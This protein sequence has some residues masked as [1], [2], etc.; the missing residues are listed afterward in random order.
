MKI[1]HVVQYIFEDLPGGIQKFV[2]DLSKLQ[3]EH[4]HE[5]VVYT[6]RPMWFRGRCSTKEN[7][8]R[9]RA[10]EVL[11]TP[12]TPFMP[13]RFLVED[14][15]VV[16]IHAQFPLVGEI[17]AFLSKIRK[18]P[19][20]VS[21]HNEAELTKTSFIVKLF[22]FFHERFLVRKL[23]DWSNTIIVTTK[24]FAQSSKVLR[25]Y[26]NKICVIP[27]GIHLNEYT[28]VS[29]SFS[30]EILYAGRIKP[31][32]GLHVL[33]EAMRIVREAIPDAQLLIA[34]EAMRRDEINYLDHLVQLV[35]SNGLQN[36]TKF[37][38]NL[39][40]ERLNKKYQ[41]V[42]LLVLPSTTRL[43]SFGQVQ[44]EAMASAVPVIVSDI[45]GPR[46]VTKGV[47]LLVPPNRPK[48]LAN[49]IIEVLRNSNLAKRMRERG[50]NVINEYR[51]GRLYAR[52]ERIYD[53]ILEKEKYLKKCR[54]KN[55]F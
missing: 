45:P 46:E 27:Y 33:V 37:L 5:V 55:N 24:S 34:G 1:L 20:I 3:I 21:Y 29:S 14:F 11:R 53:V 39:S 16:H 49:A 38:G 17:M 41:E 54:P 10:F 12:I 35:K 4:G 22:K 44:I 26:E 42:A 7:V 13:F 8:L 19:L 52:Y 15:D 36:S 9:F 6:T 25:R 2:S 51:W 31:E 28:S 50:K 40:L 23:L 43:E 30:K 32:K 47:A 48:E 18:T